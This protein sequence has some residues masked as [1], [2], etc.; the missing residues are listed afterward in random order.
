[1]GRTPSLACCFLFSPPISSGY[2]HIQGSGWYGCLWKRL[3]V[4]FLLLRDIWE[5]FERDFREGDGERERD[6]EGEIVIKVMKDLE[7]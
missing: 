4:R 7:S 2:Q 3:E 5:R 6:R 1:M